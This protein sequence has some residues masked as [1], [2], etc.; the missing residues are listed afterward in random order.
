MDAAITLPSLRCPALLRR[1]LAGFA[2]CTR[3]SRRVL[4]LVLAALAAALYAGINGVMYL[5]A[6][7]PA[8]AAPGG[9]PL[10]PAWLDAHYPP[11]APDAVTRALADHAQHGFEQPQ[12]PFVDIVILVPSVVEWAERRN[13]LRAQFARTAA[14]LPAKTSAVLLFVVGSRAYGGIGAPP[15]LPAREAAAHGDILQVDCTD[16]DGANGNAYPPADSAT[17]CKVLAGAVV[18]VERYNFHFLA[19]VGDDAFFRFDVMLSRIG[20]A[21]L[22][23]VSNLALAFWM[24]GGMIGPPEE[25]AERGGPTGFPSRSYPPYLG[26][27]GYVLSYNLTVVLATAATRVGLRDA[28][29]EDSMTGF[30]LFPFS[31]KRL[32]RVHTPCFHNHAEWV[33][34]PPSRAA[35]VAKLWA[36]QECSDSSLLIHYMTPALWKIIGEDGALRNCGSM[37]SPPYC[38]LPPFSWLNPITA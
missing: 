11:L 31:R 24:P 18:A 4:L 14:L 2:I 16:R 19:R 29:A 28:A 9:G 10:C 22:A 15:T 25:Q 38:G 33:P 1:R 3:V 17:S 7:C 5:N 8:A 6:Y 26:G 23:E 30:W 32:A 36:A 12:L 37:R 21:H 20:A 27:M 34:A 35:P 13:H